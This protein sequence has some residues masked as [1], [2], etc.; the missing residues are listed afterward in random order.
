MSNKHE[1]SFQARTPDVLAW[2][3]T[4]CSRLGVTEQRFLCL[5]LEMA[6]ERFEDSARG[7]FECED[8][9]IKQHFREEKSG[10][11]KWNTEYQCWEIDARPT[12]SIHTTV[13]MNADEKAVLSQSNSGHFETK[14]V[15]VFIPD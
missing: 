3:K 12:S 1:I 4:V 13:S 5:A 2:F 6:L 7:D 14:T 11:R 10:I 8:E 9:L 15:E